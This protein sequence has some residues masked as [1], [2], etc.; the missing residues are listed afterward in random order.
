MTEGH[1][2]LRRRSPLPRTDIEQQG[3]LPSRVIHTLEAPW[4]GLR[5]VR[6]DVESS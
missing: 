5:V 6:E 1:G 2:E 4:Y 3:F